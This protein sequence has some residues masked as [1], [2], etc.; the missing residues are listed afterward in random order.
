MPRQEERI[1]LTT[2]YSLF[3][4]LSVKAAIT[5]IPAEQL[6]KLGRLAHHISHFGEADVQ[7]LLDDAKWVFAKTR[8]AYNPHEYTV[9]ASWENDMDYIGVV[10]YIRQWGVEER[11]MDPVTGRPYL[12]LYLGEWKYWNMGY[13]IAPAPVNGEWDNTLINRKKRDADDNRT[14][15]AAAKLADDQL[16]LP[17]AKKGRQRKE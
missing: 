17:F 4:D 5:G 13:R 3:T 1:G 9:R 2:D 10:Q 8:A 12:V 16:M 7:R 11:F 15:P 6:T 14:R